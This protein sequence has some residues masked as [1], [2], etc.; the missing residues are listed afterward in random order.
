[1]NI[2]SS[3]VEVN[4]YKFIGTKS[5]K[6]VSALKQWRLPYFFGF[7]RQLVLRDKLKS[8]NL[9]KEWCYTKL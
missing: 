1:M 7:V 9:D 4:E 2:V 6:I 8:N 5:D 3:D